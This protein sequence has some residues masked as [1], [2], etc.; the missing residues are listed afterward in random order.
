VG[1]VRGVDAATLLDPVGTLEVH[2][3]VYHLHSDGREQTGLA[4]GC[5]SVEEEEEEGGGGGAPGQ[6]AQSPPAKARDLVAQSSQRRARHLQCLLSD[7]SL[8][9][10]DAL[11]LETQSFAPSAEQAVESGTP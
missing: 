8:F 9:D 10:A 7:R 3:L 1:G 4:T 6:V 11:L 2:G 5:A